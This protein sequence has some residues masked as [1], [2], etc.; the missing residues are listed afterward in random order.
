MDRVGK[1]TWTLK[2]NNQPLLTTR[3][4]VP[5]GACARRLSGRWW[6]RQKNLPIF[7][8]AAMWEEEGRRNTLHSEVVAV[9]STARWAKCLTFYFVCILMYFVLKAPAPF[10][11]HCDL[12]V[13]LRGVI[14]ES[15]VVRGQNPLQEF[16]CRL[17]DWCL[18]SHRSYMA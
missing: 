13:A 16:S 14:A 7:R 17:V 3:P 10:K 18:R 8:H 6:A 9:R 2:R 1:R 15:H 12:S 5:S 4:P 11:C